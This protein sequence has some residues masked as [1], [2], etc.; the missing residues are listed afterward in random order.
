MTDIPEHLIARS[1]KRRQEL[2]GEGGDTGASTDPAS[3]P[4]VTDAVSAAP[5]TSA[6]ATP[7]V[8]SPVPIPEPEPIK[9]WVQAAGSRQKIPVWVTPVLVFLPVWFAIYWA[10]LEPPTRDAQGPLAVGA[11]TYTEACSGCHGGNGGGGVGPQLNGGEVLVTFPDFESHVAWVI[12]GSPAVNGTPYGDAARPDGQRTSRGGMQAFVNSLDAE[13]LLAVVLYER[14]QH[15]GQPEEELALL[16]AA[17]E[18]LET[19]EVAI[20]FGEGMTGTDVAAMFAGLDLAVEETAA[21]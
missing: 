7:V 11:A 13:E 2:T 10:T 5:A 4:A 17:I 8:P 18:G 1:A 6:G 9:P 12:N 20:E 21:E 14:V 19:G 3:A 15:G 16:E